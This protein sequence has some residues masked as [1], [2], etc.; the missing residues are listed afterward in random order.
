MRIYHS[1]LFWGMVV[2]VGLIVPPTA[3]AQIKKLNIVAVE[4][5]EGGLEVQS[6]EGGGVA[7]RLGIK[8]DDVILYVNGTR[9]DSIATLQQKLEANFITVAWRSGNKFLRHSARAV[10]TTPIGKPPTTVIVIEGK[11]QE[12][13][14]PQ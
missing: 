9:I 14:R 12:V 2:L 10:R 8:K 1:I 13:D 4:L 11:A 3:T 7:A 6:V 5:K